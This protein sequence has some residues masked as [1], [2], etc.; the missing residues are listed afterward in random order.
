MT[1]RASGM[2]APLINF[3]SQVCPPL[4]CRCSP[5]SFFNFKL[6]Q[7]LSRVLK[8]VLP[9]LFFLLITG[10]VR[11]QTFDFNDNCRTAYNALISLKLDEG[12]TL[13][14]SEEKKNPANLIPVY[15]ENYYD[16]LSVY[17]SDERKLY[18]DL[19][20]NE[21]LRLAL[22]SEGDDGSP[23][24]LFTLAEVNLQWAALDIKFG[25]YLKSVFE[26]RRA[27]KLLEQNQKKFPAFQPNK[28][29]LGVL[30]ALLGSVPDKYKWGVT[31]LGLDGNVEQGMGYL[32]QLVDSTKN[33][34]YIYR[35]ETVIY[36]AFLLLNLQNK[37]EL[38]WQTLLS[39]GFPKP[40]NL[41][42]VYT[43]AHLGVYGK[44]NEEALKLLDERPVSDSFVKFPFLDYL[45]GLAKLSEL[46][47]DADASFK[48]FLVT[49]KGENHIKSSFQKIAW[50]YLLKG[51]TVNYLHFISKALK[52]GDATLD[53]DKQAKREAE[54]HRIP[55]PKL[56]RAR[57]LFDGGDYT[58][59]MAEMNAT[60][61]NSYSNADDKT[62]YLYRL[63]RI[64]SE[65][66]KPDSAL[67]YYAKAIEKGKELPRYFAANSALESA[68]IYE[69]KGDKEKAKYYYNLCLS[70][71]N[72]E[73][74]NGLDQKAKA[75]LNRLQ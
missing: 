27:F 41:F 15:L 72:H 64:Y 36:Y 8:P 55:N 48:K 34:N 16:F 32:R 75:G 45:T 6:P 26:I 69:A 18:S 22:L 47:P 50:S 19:K 74:K 51:D 56:L 17:T 65:T 25:E 44:H 4:K 39:H 38:A 33:D 68:Q 71:P 60:N 58:K 53:A 14:K 3:G 67:V 12:K 20:K 46:Q 57:L 61:E 62:E 23:Y 11:S 31:L 1:A 40:D 59:A 66:S 70:F 52:E 73:Y 10:S 2:V 28:K 30:Y 54:D 35:D 42:S 29:S 21:D 63:G 49:Y 24:F 37:N 7:Y 13:L 9:I 43:C 5:N